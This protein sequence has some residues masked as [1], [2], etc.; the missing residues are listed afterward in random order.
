MGLMMLF[1]RVDGTR[2]DASQQHDW[3]Q[4]FR[5]SVNWKTYRNTPNFERIPVINVTS[6]QTH[7]VHEKGVTFKIVILSDAHV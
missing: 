6:G 7:R 1:W 3:T 5:E 2:K 4:S